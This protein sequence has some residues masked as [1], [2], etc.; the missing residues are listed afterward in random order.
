MRRRVSVD[1]GDSLNKPDH[2]RLQDEAVGWIVR[3]DSGEWTHDTQAQF[4]AWLTTSNAH[5]VAFLRLEAGW[6]G[7]A[8]LK[9]L[10]VGQPRGASPASGAWDNSP[11]F[12]S[13][14][15]AVAPTAS[16]PGARPRR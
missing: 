13:L 2:R 4:D 5:R 11:Y 1:S 15:P 6:E 9:A 3:R 12:K 10:A 8:R 14:R 16:T 7:A